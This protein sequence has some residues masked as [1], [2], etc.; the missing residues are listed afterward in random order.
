MRSSIG[1]GNYGSDRLVDLVGNR[2]REVPHRC[3][4]VRVRQFHLCLAVSPLTFAHCRLCPLAV[5]QV[6]HEGYTLISSSFEVRGA[7]QHRHA[8]AIFEYKYL[9]IRSGGSDRLHL[10]PSVVGITPFAWRQLSPVQS[11]RNEI[12]AAV[13]DNARIVPS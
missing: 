11:T 7:D 6:D 9:L 12:V 13:P 4:A 2:G 10:R 1:V 5:G 3:E 8:V